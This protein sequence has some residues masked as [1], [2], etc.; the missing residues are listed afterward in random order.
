MRPS[1]LLL[2]IGSLIGGYWLILTQITPAPAGSSPTWLDVDDFVEYWAAGRLNLTGQ[3]PYGADELL[4]LQRQAGRDKANPLMMWNPPPVL[5]LVM[6]FGLL[7]YQ[8]A[9]LLWLLLSLTLVL[10]I[11]HHLWGA[12]GG[13][14]KLRARAL[15]L[16]FT[17]MPTLFVLDIG[18]IGVW[19]LLGLVT[20]G[21]GLR[22][23]RWAWAGAALILLAIKPHVAYLV[24]LA[25]GL[26][27]LR[28]RRW[29]LLLGAGGALA[30]TWLLPT[31][32]NPAV[33]QQYIT[34]VTTAPPLYWKTATLGNLLRLVV[35]AQYEWLQFVPPLVGSLWLLG[36]W[37]RR[38]A[39]W[40]WQIELP[41]LTLLST[42]TMAFGWPFDM[43][44][45]LLVVFQ[46][47]VWVT[48]APASPRR[49]QVIVGYLAING[50]ALLQAIGGAGLS[51]YVWLPTA[52]LLLY[53]VARP[54]AEPPAP[55]TA[56]LGQDPQSL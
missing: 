22:R 5:T 53:W 29:T 55:Q 52:C 30:V 10:V 51:H 36:E 26:W 12:Y 34:A 18:Q 39:D 47:A 44:V 31:L 3:N 9:R 56:D 4:A 46:I 23:Q 2:L 6:P 14:P 45:L 7:D 20:L 41:R 40:D 48:R 8:P 54:L 42:L 38:A 19:V 49:R 13:P 27:W 35:G 25:L 16:P 15:L 33:N 1:L 43:V 24:W 28:A 11:A 32:I 17:F 50:L 21:W 37:R